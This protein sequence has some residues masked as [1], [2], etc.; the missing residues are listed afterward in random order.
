MFSYDEQQTQTIGLNPT[1]QSC[2]DAET[3]KIVGIGENLQNFAE[4]A[5]HSQDLERIFANL[6]EAYNAGVAALDVYRH[7]LTELSYLEQGYHG[8]MTDEQREA[9]EDVPEDKRA[10][11]FH[12]MGGMVA[13]FERPSDEFRDVLKT[14]QKQIFDNL[15]NLAEQS[16]ISGQSYY[17][18]VKY[19]VNL[20][21]LFDQV[22]PGDDTM[23]WVGG[24]AAVGGFILG[25]ESGFKP[26]KYL[27][28]LF[29]SD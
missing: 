25:S 12:L 5:R 16:H 28:S 9:M 24:L 23:F 14:H 1:F 20:L 7:R 27:G 29:G 11:V 6:C 17:E 3:A 4:M 15:R 22:Q 13:C 2:L 10:A 26:M 19:I 21:C 8:R 18:N